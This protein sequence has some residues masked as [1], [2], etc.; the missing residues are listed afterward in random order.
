MVGTIGGLPVSV[1]DERLRYVALGHIHRML[2]VQTGDTREVWY[3]GTP[4]PVRF[5]EAKTDRKA[6]VVTVD[7]RKT[8]HPETLTIPVSR[9]LLE[10]SGDFDSVNASVSTLTNSAP[11]PTLLKVTLEVDNFQ[12]TLTSQLNDALDRRF[13]GRGLR[14]IIA[15]IVQVTSASIERSEGEVSVLKRAEM[16]P[17]SVFEQLCVWQGEDFE[18]LRPLLEQLI[19]SSA[20]A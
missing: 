15:D 2:P 1:F 6:L 14:P 4:I 16:N 5:S 3:S 17:I 12:A 10:I 9:E 7:D 18:E 19:Q 8:Y 11:L 13:E 20:E